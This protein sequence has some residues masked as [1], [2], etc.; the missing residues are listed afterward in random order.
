[1]KVWFTA[2]LHFGHKNIL[3]FTS[4]PY[5]SV[6]DMDED[7]IR[8]WQDTVA[9][10]DMVFVL[11]DFSF[12]RPEVTN[13]ILRRLPGNKF[14]VRG[15]HDHQKTLKKIH[16][17]SWVRD[18]YEVKKPHLTVLSHYPFEVWRNSH[19]GSFHLHG[20]SHGGSIQR[21]RRLDVGADNLS[22]PILTPFDAIQGYLESRPP[23]IGDYHEENKE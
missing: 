18:Y 17:W 2:D 5:S 20:H 9:P 1:M 10:G 3:K 7:F 16:G 23:F 22:F 8:Q 14:L 4:R 12:H 6:E 11:G 13:S 19:R 21:G 15:N